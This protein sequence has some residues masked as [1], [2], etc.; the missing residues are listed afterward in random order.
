MTLGLLPPCGA[1]VVLWS[2]LSGV[3]S[4]R[5]S[6]RLERVKNTKYYLMRNIENY[7]KLCTIEMDLS[8]LP[9]P[10]LSKPSG[11]GIYYR[12]DYEV[13]LLFGLTELQAMVAWKENVSPILGYC[14]QF[15]P[16]CQGVERRSA[17]EII[18]DPDSANDGL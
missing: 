7:T 8:H 2:S 17:A 15:L 6:L 16:V 18:Y 10:P 4:I 14:I 5:V 9:L 11:E 1:T 3:T 12:I 13:I